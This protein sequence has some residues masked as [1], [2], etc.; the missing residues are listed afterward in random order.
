MYDPT[1]GRFL[2]EDPIGLAGG[3]ANFYRYCGNSPTNHVD[4][5]GLSDTTYYDPAQLT[6][7]WQAAQL[8]AVQSS[9]QAEINQVAQD[10]WEDSPEG[11]AAAQASLQ[12]EISRIA[13]GQAAA[14]EA[15]E[16]VSLSVTWMKANGPWLPFTNECGDQSA[17]LANYLLNHAGGGRGCPCWSVS[18]KG[19]YATFLGAHLRVGESITV[20]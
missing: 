16:L 18:T 4:P 5:T 1:A 19:G 13:L 2:E 10:A 7:S 14:A 12:A 8:S 9:L 11:V 17:S 3:D 6:A 15:Q 20:A